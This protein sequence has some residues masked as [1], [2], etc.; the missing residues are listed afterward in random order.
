MAPIRITRSTMWCSVDPAR[1][2]GS[3]RRRSRARGCLCH[4]R[5]RTSISS[6]RGHDCIMHAPVVT[7]CH[8]L[9]R[10]VSRAQAH[11]HC[12]APTCLKMEMWNNDTGALLCRQ[13]PVYGGTGVIDRA[14]YDEERYIATPPCMVRR[15]DLKHAPAATPTPHP[16]GVAG[17]Q[18]VRAQS[19][20]DR[21]H[22]AVGLCRARARAS[23]PRE[24]HDDPR[25]LG[26]QQH[27]RPPRRDG[28]AGGVARADLTPRGRAREARRGGASPG[29][30]VQS[31]RHRRYAL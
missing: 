29:S 24:R 13:E 17:A 27:V 18:V 26:H 1:R 5:S 28:A 14:D 8:I 7:W 12:H 21:V 19:T 25:R 10:H 15:R 4:P 31:T 2:W 3:A 30:D 20:R 11:F 22:V 23:A 16:P 6:R 9:K